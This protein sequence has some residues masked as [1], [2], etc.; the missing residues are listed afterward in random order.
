MRDSFEDLD[1]TTR[2]SF[3]E[4]AAKSL[5]GVSVLPASRLFAAPGEPAKPAAKPA[6]K[7][8]AKAV[9]KT[10]GKSPAS[11]PGKA[12]YVIYLY[13]SGG[14]SHID[15]FDVKPGTKNQGEIKPIQTNVPGMSFGEFLPGLAK[16][17][18]QLA[19]VR[20]LSTETG[21]HEQGR[22]FML[23]S[24]KEIATTRHPFLGAWAQNLLGKRNKT[25]PDS[26]LIG[27]ATRHPG[28]G[29]FDP[30]Y[31]PLP[32][33][34][35]NAGLQNTKSPAYLSE[36]SFDKRLHLIDAFDSSFRGRYKQKEVQAYNDFYKQATRLL[37]SDELKGF[38][39]KNEPAEKRDEYGQNRFGQGCLLA[40]RLI[41]NNIRFA[42][43]EC[44]G[45][46]NH[47]DIHDALEPKA[48]MLDQGLSALLKDLES[49]G[50][51]KE[52]LIVV[53]TEFGRSPVINQNA[54]RDHHPG[55]F[56]C[57]LAG[58]GIKG[59]QFY[60]T[61]DAE[62]HS[63][64]D[65]PVKVADFN[66]TIAMAMGMPLDKEVYSKAGRPFKVAHDGQPLK[67]LFG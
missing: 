11:G 45:F 64:K 59:G 22:Y 19:V 47:I 23:T 39:L 13:M 6:A 31:S 1:P 4:V 36:K 51:L 7:S 5:L 58:G 52:T 46:D 62:G 24:Y 65:N 53:A 27:G 18:H 55:V 21:A 9:E 17:A 38:D 40:R 61:S 33:D 49:K 42:E 2:R 50:L 14:M 37:S 57:V 44:G 43:V 26:V 28:A 66:A 16:H 10:P 54:G 34:D 29:F 60:G 20:S 15:T 12:K 8:P 41:E 63:P 56:S 32:I 3:M 48:A 67:K 35:P 25:L 30:S